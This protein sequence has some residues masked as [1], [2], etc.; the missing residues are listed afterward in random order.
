MTRKDLLVK[1]I[2]LN[3]AGKIKFTTKGEV[4]CADADVVKA[5]KDIPLEIIARGFDAVVIFLKAFG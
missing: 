1:I 4:E 5:F 3:Q 2:A